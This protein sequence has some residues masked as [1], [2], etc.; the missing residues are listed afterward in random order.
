M[1]ATVCRSSFIVYTACSSRSY[2][3]RTDQDG[4]QQ[5]EEGPGEHTNSK[6][7][8]QIRGRLGGI[9]NIGKNEGLGR[10]WAVNKM[11]TAANSQSQKWKENL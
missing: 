2:K 8:G 5:K 9:R 11:H 10:T 1:R 6:A 7:E 4:M 3:R